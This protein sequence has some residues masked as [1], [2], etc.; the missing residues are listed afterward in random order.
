MQVREKRAARHKVDDDADDVDAEPRRNLK[1]AGATPYAPTG[2]RE[3]EAPMRRSQPR[4]VAREEPPARYP[5]EAARDVAGTTAE[6]N[7]NELIGMLGQVL[8]KLDKR[9]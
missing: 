8:A 5:R 2:R 6:P 4:E 3:E 1:D 9:Q 7:M